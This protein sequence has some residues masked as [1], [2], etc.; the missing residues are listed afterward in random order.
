MKKL[1]ASTKDAT[2]RFDETLIKLFEKKVKCE[3]ATYQ[4]S[5]PTHTQ[6]QNMYVKHGQI[7]N[8]ATWDQCASLLLPL[9]PFFSFSPHRI[10]GPL[11]SLWFPP[12]NNYEIRYF[13]YVDILKKILFNVVFWCILQEELKITY[14]VYSVIIEE[15]MRNRELELKLKLEKTLAYKVRELFHSNA[16]G[17]YGCQFQI[18]LFERYLSEAWWCS[19]KF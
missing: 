15:E 12:C 7:H 14:L 5:W 19:S 13:V 3:M 4:V 17:I 10:K 9:V 11:V 6:M 18:L 1:Q 2:E 16:E 8:T